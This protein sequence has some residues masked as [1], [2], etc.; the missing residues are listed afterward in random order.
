[1][2]LPS[3]HHLAMDDNDELE[4]F[5]RQWREEVRSKEANGGPSS[6]IALR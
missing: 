4:S 5:R 6:S 1:M 2:R 3:Y